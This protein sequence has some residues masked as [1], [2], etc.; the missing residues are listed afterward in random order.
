MVANKWAG[1]EDVAKVTVTFG[2][3]ESSLADLI[4]GWSAQVLK[5]YRDLDSNWNNPDPAIWGGDDLTGSYHLRDAIE[6]GLDLLEAAIGTRQVATLT[7]TDELLRSFTVDDANS[8]K[9]FDSTIGHRPGWW[10]QR[11][12]TRGPVVQQLA[13]MHST[14][15]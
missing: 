8:L 5:F 10:W 14:Q 9:V 12:P 11:F 13:E 2:P 15:S 1:A 3:G 6:S 7:A 4:N